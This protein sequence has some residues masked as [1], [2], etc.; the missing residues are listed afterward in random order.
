MRFEPASD[1]STRSD[2][3]TWRT[4]SHRG[5]DSRSRTAVRVRKATVGSDRRDSRAA[6]GWA[7]T[8]WPLPADSAAALARCSSPAAPNEARYSPTGQPSVR[9]ISSVTSASLSRTP[10]C[11]SSALASSSSMASSSAPISSSWPLGCDT[12]SGSDGLAREASASCERLGSRSATSATASRHSWLTSSSRL[13]RT[14]VTGRVIDASPATNLGTRLAEA[15]A[16]GE[17]RTRAICGSI[18]STRSSAAAR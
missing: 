4:A 18:G 16:P 13:S 9:S 15:A 3:L 11:S 8:G 12:A 6:G 5:P 7:A 1:S 17:A 10:A 2:P 14:T